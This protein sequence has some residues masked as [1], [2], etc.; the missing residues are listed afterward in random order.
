MNVNIWRTEGPRWTGARGSPAKLV[1]STRS[2][3]DL[4]VSPNGQKI[5]FASNRAGAYEIWICDSNGSNPVQLTSLSASNSGT[6]RWSPDGQQI[7]FDSRKEGHSDIYVINA[8]G[9]SPR[10]LTTEPFENNVPSWSRDGR[11]I[12]YSSD[13]TGTA[14]LWKIPAQGGQAVQVTKKGGF[15]AFESPNG[16]FLYYIK[17][18]DGPIWRMP[19]EGG[20]ETRILDQNIRWSYW[21]VLEN[22]ICFLDW[23]ATP[24]AIEL[25]DFDTRQL[26]RIAIVDRA[27][28][29]SGGGGFAVSP[30]GQSILFARIDQIDSEIMLVENFR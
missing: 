29:L 4:D 30:D 24:P 16:K 17:A 5:T 28:G 3:S 11:W 9:G 21:R 1:S 25:F 10:R 2:Q 26:K 8:E 19:V 23:G 14:E 22:G 7:A 12:Y 27:K 18:F 15:A 13:R 6:P 20:E